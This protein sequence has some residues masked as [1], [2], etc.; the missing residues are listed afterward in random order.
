MKKKIIFLLIVLF[1]CWLVGREWWWKSS[2]PSVPF[3]TV[4]IEEGSSVAQIADKLK[5]EKIIGSPYLF[6]AYTKLTGQSGVLQ[7]GEFN[8][9]RGMS[10]SDVLE[11]ITDARANEISLTFIEGWTLTQIGDYLESQG[12]VSKSEWSA[13]ASHDLEGYLFPDTYRFLK[14]VTAEEIVSRM[15]AEMD[16]K[17]NAEMRAELERNG[18]SV[19]EMLT[20]A[21]IIEKEVS[22]AEDRKKISDIFW[23]RLAIGMALQADSTVNY[24]T[25]KNTPAIS[26]EDR[27]VD[28]P[29]NTYKYRGLPPGPISNPGASAIEAAVYPSSNPYYF[30]LTDEGGNVWY[31]KT[32]E[33]HNANKARYR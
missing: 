31:A 6:K 15:R 26:Y 19:H 30:F 2:G 17:I 20:M 25:G 7:A 18:T 29:Y 28:S 22:S 3:V 24:I 16:E 33:E 32:L 14:G 10:A 11:I 5:E 8:L 13:A 9:S 4:V 21:S 1:L 12:V 27:D 23:K